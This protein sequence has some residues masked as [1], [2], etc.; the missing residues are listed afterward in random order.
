V[1]A[2]QVATRPGGA[3]E[4]RRRAARTDPW[5]PPCRARAAACESAN[6]LTGRPFVSAKHYAANSMGDRDKDGVACDGA[7]RKADFRPRWR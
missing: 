4:R 6:G 5:R 2:Q 1:R 3:Q 7:P